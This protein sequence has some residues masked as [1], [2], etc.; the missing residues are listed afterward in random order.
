ML[1]GL[2]DWKPHLTHDAF[3]IACVSLG[4]KISKFKIS[5]LAP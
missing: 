2:E 5:L 3:I 1:K 4:S